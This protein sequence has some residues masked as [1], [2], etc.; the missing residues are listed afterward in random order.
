MTRQEYI[1]ARMKEA[2]RSIG[3]YAK[4]A[5]EPMTRR[6]W[7]R[8]TFRPEN[9]T[10]ELRDNAGGFKLY[11]VDLENCTD[12]ARILDWFTQVG[13]MSD[14]TPENFFNLFLAMNDLIRLQA[15]L[16]GFGRNKTI[17]P[18]QIISEIT[19]ATERER[20]TQMKTTQINNRPITEREATDEQAPSERAVDEFEQ[21]V[22]NIER[23]TQM[24]EEYLRDVDRE[25]LSKSGL[26]VTE[27]FTRDI[28]AAVELYRGQEAAFALIERD[29]QAALERK[30]KAEKAYLEAQATED[31]ESA[32]LLRE[33]Q[34]LQEELERSDQLILS[35]SSKPVKA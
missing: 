21:I 34:A 4:M 15:N 33:Q 29:R 3:E 27:S 10:L 7:G 24:A 2:F 11:E 20:S 17:D 19:G 1:R 5:M 9:W 13:E 8:W 31:T 25:G 14:I 12:S 28:R 26:L 6:Q 16:C 30:A 22:A 32:E 18:K 23:D 35:L